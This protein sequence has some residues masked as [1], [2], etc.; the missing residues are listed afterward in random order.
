MSKKWLQPPSVTVPDSLRDAVG[1]HALIAESLVRRG[2]EN[3]SN[4]HRF[5]DPAHYSPASPDELPDMDKAVGRLQKAISTGERILVWGDFDVDGQTATSLLVSALRDLGAKVSYHVPN[6]F[7]EGHGIH[8]P[9]LKTLLDSGVDLLLTCDTGIAAH[10]AIHYAQRRGVDVVVTDHHALPPIRPAAYAAVNPMRLPEG[11]PLRELP[12]VG[13]AYKLIEALYGSRSSD[14]LLDLVAM[15]I[16]ADVMVQVDDTRY[17]L[18]RGLDVLRSGARPGLKAMMERAEIDPAELTEMDIGF[19]LGPRL[20]ALGRLADANPAVELLT[21]DDPALIA[22]R[23]TE[24][25]GLNQRRRFLTRQIYEA[26]QQQIESDP[27]L[28]KYAALVIMSEGWHSGILGIVASRLVENYNCPVIVLSEQEGIASGSARSVAGVNII[29]AI[30]SQSKLL[31]GYGGHTMAAGLSLKAEDVFD[32]RRGISGVV[33]ETLDRAEITPELRIDG[34]LDLGEIDL[35]LAEDIGRL[36]PFGNGNP[37]LTLATRGVHVKSRRKL[38]SRGD[39]LAL[40]LEDEQGQTQR[41]IW[42]FADVDAVPEGRFDI[43]YTLRPN[44]FNGKREALMEWLDARPDETAVEVVLPPTY[45]VVDYRVHNQPDAALREVRAQYED[46]L[47]WAEAGAKIEGGIS[48]YGLHEAQTLAVW[49]VPPD[50][51][52]WRAA[53]GTVQPETIV[54][55]GHTPPFSNAQDL[56][57]HLVGVAKYAL[58]AK[59]GQIHL[60]DMAALTG[61][62]ERLIIA[63]IRWLNTQSELRFEHLGDGLYMVSAGHTPAG[64]ADPEVIQT[65]NRLLREAQAYQQY[66][67]HSSGNVRRV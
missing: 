7:S 58:R 38:G 62:S 55:F 35:P 20:N 51:T 11:H 44:V 63:C 23:V 33:R 24:L 32:L 31:R 47:V 9:T 39:H 40:T 36:A 54:L 26:A 3:V 43:A 49:T 67:M 6:R 21:S 52:V 65:I 25:E 8:L 19:S 60:N 53:L 13:V 27:S 28:L 30:R 42:W 66:W 4:A 34:W 61:Q 14:H 2:I 5:L 64:N 50:V 1:G 15:G 17:L 10:E 12:G 59:G 29:E 41:V 22:E 37:P 16:V 56:L 45:E 18:Q 48:R 57:T 46:V